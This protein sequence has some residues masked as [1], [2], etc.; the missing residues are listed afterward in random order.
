MKSIGIATLAT[1]LS[2]P[3]QAAE[4]EVQLSA[5]VVAKAFLAGRLE[6]QRNNPDADIEPSPVV[7]YSAARCRL[8]VLAGLYDCRFRVKYHYSRRWFTVSQR[9]QLTDGR[10]VISL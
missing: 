10:W 9:L 3:A 5:D 7:R 8:S 2:I 1:C 6:A 4:R